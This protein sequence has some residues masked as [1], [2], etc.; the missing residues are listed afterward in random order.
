MLNLCM[1]VQTKQLLF[2]RLLNN[3]NKIKS[4]G[5]NKLGVFG[6]LVNGTPKNDSDIDLLVEF[7]VSKKK[8]MII[9]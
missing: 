6:S 4:F 2:S 7:E 5:V 9:I 1:D 3:S 8:T